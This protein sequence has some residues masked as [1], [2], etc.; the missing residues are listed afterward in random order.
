MKRSG[1]ASSLILTLALVGTFSTSISQA[2]IVIVRATPEDMNAFDSIVSRKLGKPSPVIAKN[3]SMAV[4]ADS[5][6]ISSPSR[7]ASGLGRQTPHTEDSPEN[8]R[9]EL[10]QAALK[11]L[12]DLDDEGFRGVLTP[13]SRSK[14][15]SHENIERLRGIV[16]EHRDLRL[17]HEVIEH[18]V[19]G[20][21]PNG[22]VRPVLQ[23]FSGSVETVSSAG[24]GVEVFKVKILCVRK[25][26]KD[27]E[28]PSGGDSCLFQD[29][30]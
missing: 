6:Q 13:T 10:V 24:S 16:A 28:T 25:A 5:K 4:L 30:H 29:F 8:A 23:L 14:I 19:S 1:R 2:D 3:N 17:A 18:S 21:G 26:K 12:Q 9:T 20:P 11:A 27:D 7:K 22:K 15:G